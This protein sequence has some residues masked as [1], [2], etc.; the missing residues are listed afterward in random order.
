MLIGHTKLVNNKHPQK[1]ICIKQLIYL[2][3]DSHDSI[4][5]HAAINVSALGDEHVVYTTMLDPQQ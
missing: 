4:Q 1:H 2:E 3:V 5:I